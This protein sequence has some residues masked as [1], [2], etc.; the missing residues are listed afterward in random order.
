MALAPATSINENRFHLL[1][2]LSA[3][4]LEHSKGHSQLFHCAVAATWLRY[5][6][7]KGVMC[8]APSCFNLI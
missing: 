8:L 7:N 1:A 6:G 2:L 3:V 4:Q 5:V